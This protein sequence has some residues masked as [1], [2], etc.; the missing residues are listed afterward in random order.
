MTEI[1][2][3]GAFSGTLTLKGP[4]SQLER[5]VRQ[6]GGL[7]IR[8]VKGDA[9]NWQY[10]DAVYFLT[11]EDPAAAAALTDGED[12]ITGSSVL[13]IF[14]ARV[15]SE[16]GETI[17]EP[18]GEPIEAMLFENTYTLN[19]DASEGG[20]SSEGDS[21]SGGAPSGESNPKTGDSAIV[22][23]WLS[24]LLLSATAASVI[25]INKKRLTR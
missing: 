18:V 9:E 19:T 11:Y 12:S 17:Y 24:A 5:L 2:G 16:N 1:N 4:K 8:Q 14:K 22:L 23:P 10:S 13:R 6:G 7:F 15:S 25:L 3:E 21:S 20:S